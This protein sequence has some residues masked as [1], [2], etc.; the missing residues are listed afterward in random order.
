MTNELITIEDVSNNALAVFTAENDTLDK[1]LLAIEAEAL[2]LVPDVSTE[3]GREAISSNAY[4]V[5]QAKARIEKEG[6][7]L[8]DKQKEI[9]KLI[10]ASRKK[11]KD[12]L[13]NLQGRVKQQLTDWLA[14]EAE[15]ARII[16]NNKRLMQS[17]TVTTT[18]MSNHDEIAEKRAEIHAVTVN[19]Y[20][21]DLEQEAIESKEAAL[22]MLLNAEHKLIQDA[23][24]LALLLNLKFDTDK[25]A[26]AVES[27]K[28]RLAK[29]SADRERAEREE[30][31]R[32]ERDARIAKEA[33]EKAER[34]AKEAIERAQREA[35]QAKEREK[36]AEERAEKQR[37]E[38]IERAEL[39]KQAAIEADRKRIEAE[40]L[41][42]EAKEQVE[43]SK[44]SHRRKVNNEIKALLVDFGL[45]DETATSIIKLAAKGKLGALS[46]NY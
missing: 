36:Q 17:F 40:R 23:H 46:I 39:E 43:A 20:F 7:A 5:A 38:A 15:K 18:N 19:S 4:K 11:A 35:E 34:E 30:K 24:E 28:T 41:A 26:A 3:K 37:I 12:F 8:A 6:K 14:E 22:E 25:A 33:T 29:E 32:A 31:E 27:E 16:E 13:E 21:G 42:L 2:A 9:P 45:D 44:L 1:I 10:D